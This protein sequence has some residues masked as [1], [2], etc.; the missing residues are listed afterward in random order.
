M[1][2]ILTELFFLSSLVCVCVYIHIHIY[3]YICIYIDMKG[4]G[5]NGSEYLLLKLS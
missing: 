4:L 5:I 3:I 1:D 2:E